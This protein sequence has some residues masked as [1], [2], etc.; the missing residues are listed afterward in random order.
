[1]VQAYRVRRGTDGLSPLNPV[2]VIKCR[3][4]MPGL[5]M[6][7]MAETEKSRAI[8]SDVNANGKGLFRV[9]HDGL[10]VIEWSKAYAGHTMCE[11]EALA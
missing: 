3:M 2:Y 6:I 5:P 10:R 8:N 1:M 7:Y 4:R 11:K 9:L